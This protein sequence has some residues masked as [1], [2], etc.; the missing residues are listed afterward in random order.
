MAKKNNN[1]YIYK[2]KYKEI[3]ISK[4]GWFVFHSELRDYLYTI[5]G[6]DFFLI[7]N[8]NIFKYVS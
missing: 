6:I 3:N 7:K 8:I 2:R 4:P 1:D 5:R